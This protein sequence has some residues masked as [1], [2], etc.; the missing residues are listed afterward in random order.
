LEDEL[1][2]ALEVGDGVEGPIL[3]KGLSKSKSGTMSWLVGG[4]PVGSAKG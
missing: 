3:P 1:D 4:V 2:P